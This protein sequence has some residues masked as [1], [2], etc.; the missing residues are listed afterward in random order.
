MNNPWRFP[1]KSLAALRRGSQSAC[2]IT[3]LPLELA[4]WALWHCRHARPP[5]ATR[6]AKG[7]PRRFALCCP[8]LAHPGRIL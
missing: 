2:L 4:F 7:T 8:R 3:C 5:D 6:L 1:C